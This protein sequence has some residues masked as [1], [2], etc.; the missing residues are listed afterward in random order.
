[1]SGISTR[2]VSGFEKFGTGPVMVDVGCYSRIQPCG[3]A[4]TGLS[5]PRGREAGR[6]T[7]PR[8]HAEAR[9]FQRAKPCGYGAVRPW[10]CEVKGLGPSQIAF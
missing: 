6:W 9:W 2:F 7:Q 8:G 10:S 5:R 3:I 4:A 1:M